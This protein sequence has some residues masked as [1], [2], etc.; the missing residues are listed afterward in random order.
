MELDNEHKTLQL[1]ALKQELEM[2]V[3]DLNDQQ[4]QILLLELSRNKVDRGNS[5]LDKINIISHS[6]DKVSMNAE[7]VW[8]LLQ[9]DLEKLNSKVDHSE[10][11]YTMAQDCSKRI[12]LMRQLDKQED[13]LEENFLKKLIEVFTEGMGSA[14]QVKNIQAC[15]QEVNDFKRNMDLNLN[16]MVNKKSYKLIE[17]QM[18]EM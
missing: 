1:E 15:L 4:I 14:D 17:E 3:R 18:A 5:R 7:M 12:E 9:M 13:G 11:L 10:D 16:E 2:H 8:I 6:V